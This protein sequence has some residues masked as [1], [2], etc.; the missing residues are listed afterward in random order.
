[1]N[2]A[3][4][5]CDQSIIDKTSYYYFQTTLNKEYNIINMALKRLDRML[6]RET[7]LNLKH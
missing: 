6:I 5:E 7:Q 4:A 2:V 3:R 1:M